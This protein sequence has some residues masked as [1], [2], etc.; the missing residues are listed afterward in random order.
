MWIGKGLGT[1]EEQLAGKAPQTQFGRAMEQLGVE[2]I[3]ANS[4][5]AKGR[6][7]RM[8]GTLQ[9]R[10]VKSLRLEEI[11][12]LGKANEYLRQVFLPAL[13]RKFEVQPASA[14]D[15]HRDVPQQ[16]KQILS[17]EVKRVVQRDWTVQHEGQWY[18]L[19]RRH[20]TLALAS[21][22]VI[23]R[24]LRDGSVQL[25]RGDRK[26]NFKKLSVRP[27]RQAQA[28]AVKPRPP[29]EW[30][31]AATHPWRL[32]RVGRAARLTTA[33]PQGARARA[34]SSPP[35]RSIEKPR[36][37]SYTTNNKGTLSPEFLRGH[38]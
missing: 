17:W 32:G 28:A 23:V 24:K 9:D 5:Q 7:E 14:A 12:D 19:D 35:A 2:L 11:N 36:L 25:L 4:P 13:N 18:Q 20:E 21:K 37:A 22:S 31:P 16:L 30:T 38:F 10:L 26:L 3:L 15:V 33:R 1:I 8:N 29:K 6:V 34:R 27:K